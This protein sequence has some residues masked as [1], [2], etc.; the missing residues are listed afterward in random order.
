MSSATLSQ[1]RLTAQEI[2]DQAAS[3]RLQVGDFHEKLV[4]ATYAEAADIADSVVTRPDRARRDSLDQ[5]IDR[6]VTSRLW[7]FPLMVLLFAVVFW[8]TIS[9]A[10]VRS[11]R[12][13]RRSP[14]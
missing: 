14:G 7:G 6:L 1:E 4:E 12:S 5:R 8:I 10:N 3:L 11:G 13:R 2:L 9:G